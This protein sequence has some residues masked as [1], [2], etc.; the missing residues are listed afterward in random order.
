MRPPRLR[1]AAGAG[2]LV[3]ALVLLGLVAFAPAAFAHHPIVSGEAACS[4]S[5]DIVVTWTVANSE[6]DAAR[7]MTIDA[8][9]VTKGTVSGL[10]VGD[11][12]APSGSTQATTTLPGNETGTVSLSVTGRWKYANPDVVAT[13][14]SGPVSLPGNCRPTPLVDC[15]EK[16]PDGTLRSHLGWSNTSGQAVT[17]PQGENTTNGNIVAGSIPTSFANGS[18][19]FTV[20]HTGPLAWT[21]F[22]VTVTSGDGNDWCRLGIR[23]SKTVVNNGQASVGP[24]SFTVTGPNGF[25]TQVEVPAGGETLVELDGQTGTFTVTEDTSGLSVTVTP[26][27]SQQ[28]DVDFSDNSQPPVV[29]FTNDYGGR[30]RVTK[31]VTGS[32]RP[33]NWSFDVQVDCGSEP[34]TVTLSDEAPVWTSDLLPLGTSCTVTEPDNG[35]AASTQIT[36]SPATVETGQTVDVTVVNDFPCRAGCGGGGTRST[37]TTAPT[38]TTSQPPTTT[39]IPPTTTTVPATPPTS[40]LGEVIER[41]ATTVAPARVQGETLARTGGSRDLLLLLAGASLVIGGLLL[42]AGA[43]TSD[44]ASA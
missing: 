14:S 38:T 44:K 15:T 28:V 18:G 17:P 11:T 39:T 1:R 23:V 36:G 24:F 2:L 35:D 26:S 12:V 43:P 33:D 32:A 3:Q 7:T 4:P 40:V 5:G 25:S 42:L 6:S 16:L 19:S 37:T 30:V 27:P 41:P 13:R 20:D 34:F 29:S 8:L 10:A 9:S 31:Q 22:G 21:L